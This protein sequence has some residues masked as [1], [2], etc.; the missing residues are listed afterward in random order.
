MPISCIVV[1]FFPESRQNTAVFTH[2]LP[3]KRVVLA[4]VT[5]GYAL[6]LARSAGRGKRTGQTA[7]GRR[8]SSGTAGRGCLLQVT[9][10]LVGINLRGT[11]TRQ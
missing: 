9:V 5:G 4:T 3:L 8:R 10:S 6:V 7:E 1:S 11:S 2:K